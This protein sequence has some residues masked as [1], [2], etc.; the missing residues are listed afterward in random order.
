[1]EFGVFDHMD[2]G[3]AGLSQQIAERLQLVAAYD[4]W[5]F[6]AYHL[7]EH[8]GTP[9][10]LAPAPSVFLAAVAQHTTRL[11]FGPLVYCLPLYHPLRLIEEI[12]LL[13]QM[14]AGRLELGVGRGISPI[15]VGFYGVDPGAG[16]RQFA[17]ALA[18]I[19]QGLKQGLAGKALTHHGAFLCLRPGSH[20]HAA[21][22]AAPSPI[23]VRRLEPGKYGL[24]SSQRREHRHAPAGSGCSAHH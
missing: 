1:M 20:G 21:G 24:G 10:G 5:G 14:S 11:R 19:K 6:S 18:V 3:P 2:V 8:H 13:D 17:E 7:A 15:E 23:V 9:L 22:P 4:R 12:C 16:P